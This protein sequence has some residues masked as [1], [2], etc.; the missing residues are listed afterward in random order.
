MDRITNNN[1]NGKKFEVLASELRGVAL[2]AD[3]KRALF[4]NLQTYTEAHPAPSE[5][6]MYTALVR[7]LRSVFGPISWK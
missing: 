6:D 1:N 5:G 2:A 7:V 3:E 4:N